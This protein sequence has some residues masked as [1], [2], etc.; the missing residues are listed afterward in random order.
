MSYDFSR[1]FVAPQNPSGFDPLGVGGFTSIDT[2]AGVVATYTPSADG[3]FLDNKSPVALRWEMRV[4][5]PRVFRSGIGRPKFKLA[6]ADGE[7]H[8]YAGNDRVEVIPGDGTGYTVDISATIN[9]GGFLRFRWE[10]LDSAD[11]GA[12][13]RFSASDDYGGLGPVTSG[14]RGVHSDGV[15]VDATAVSEGVDLRNTFTWAGAVLAGDKWGMRY[16]V[17]AL[18]VGVV[19]DGANCTLKSTGRYVSAF[20]A[21]YL[22]SGSAT[23]SGAIELHATS[24][25][26][27]LFMFVDLTATFSLVPAM[28]S[29]S[30]CQGSIYFSTMPYNKRYGDGLANAGVLH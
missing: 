2:S 24:D 16:N 18:P 19:Y 14:T 3:G 26:K 27:R 29:G 5:F 8:S 17:D 25:V 7:V 11:G 10:N 6:H 1:S 20:V 13:V 12:R 9:P 21:M 4:K 23:S 28:T 15:A 30:I 22:Q